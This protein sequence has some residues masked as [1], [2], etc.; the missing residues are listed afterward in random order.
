MSYAAVEAIEEAFGATRS[1]L[2]PFRLKRW[3]VLAV[4]V[5]FVSGTTGLD[6]NTNVG[7]V[8][9]PVD[10][11]PP[12]GVDRPVPPG[13]EPIVGPVADVGFEVVLLLGAVALV[14]V[15]LMALIAAIME[16]V[17]VR[18]A[19]H[20]DVRIRGYFGPNTGKGLSLFVLRALIAL[21][22]LATVLFVLAAALVG[23]IAVL[24]ILLLFSPFIAVGLVA[25]YVFHR[26]TVDFVVP[27]AL[28]D[29]VGIFGAW[30][31]FVPELRAALE[32]YAVYALVRFG[33]GIVA[34]VVTFIGI[35]A[36]GIVVAIPFLLVLAVLFALETLVGLGG[37]FVVLAGIV[38]FFFLAT[39]FVAGVTLVQVPVSTYLRYYSL[40]VLADVSPQYDLVEGVR[41]DLAPAD[42]GAHPGGEEAAG[43][44]PAA[45]QPGMGGDDAGIDDEEPGADDE[46]GPGAGDGDVNENGPG[47]SDGDVDED[48]DR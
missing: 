25:I 43:D 42:A 4:V 24:G 41:R 17:F 44:E 5:F 30:R 19:Q 9:L 18:I 3:L 7:S 13:A 45:G 27:V 33:L 8:D 2:L 38:V 14:V 36:I 28:V 23:G 37:L 21:V 40:L 47:A 26:F 11:A 46:G 16:F 12:P 32:E 39:V 22:V 10:P 20:R 31:R 15:I 48:G 1:L 6:L 34:A 35:A 29:D